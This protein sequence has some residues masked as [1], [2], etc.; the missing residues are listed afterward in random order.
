[1]DTPT[2]TPAQTRWQA[3]GY[4]LFLHFGPNTFAGTAWGDGTFPAARVDLRGVDARQWAGMAAEAGMKYALLTVK[5][6]DGYCLWP[7]RQTDYCVRASPGGR[8]V[9][10]DFVSACRAAGLRPGFYYSLWD[11]HEPCY[12]DDVAYAAF[13]RAQ[14]TELLTGY[15]DLV[16]VWFDGAWDKDYPTRHWEFN[17]AWERD[18]AAANYRPGVRWEWAALYAHLHQLQPEL[19]VLNNSSSD[20][21]GVPR[22]FPVDARTCEHFDF[23]Y[24]GR[25]WPA[26]TRCDW[27]DPAG[28]AVYLPLE[29]DVTMG[30]DWFYL[31]KSWYVH[32]S[33]A[34]LV[35]WYRRARAVQAN[36]LFNL[37]P[38][39]AGVLPEY[40]RPYLRAAAQEL[41]G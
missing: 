37:G 29:Y 28:R 39:P 1:M 38:T 32:P 33:A 24:N 15:G 34:T 8:D 31:E 21:P 22:V 11:R 4:G 20:R 25:G 26:A 35:D 14:M 7:T 16:E 18:P 40:H 23:V 30:R 10:G 17:P 19:M 36:L 13:M 12:E 3:L 6:H 41:W 2:P 9:F 5:H 27:T